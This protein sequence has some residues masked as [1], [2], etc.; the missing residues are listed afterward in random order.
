[1]NNKGQ[2]GIGALLLVFVAVIVGV[3]LFQSSAQSIGSAVNT[4]TLANTTI[5][6]PANGT[7]YVFSG[8][9]SLSSVVVYNGSAL[10]PSTNYT[11]ANDQIVNGL[12][13]ATITPTASAEYR[14]YDWNV[15]AIA[16]PDTYIA[17]GGARSIT[18]LVLVFSALAIAV[19][20]LVPS[21][22]SGVLD[23]FS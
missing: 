18:S 5:D 3:A 15:S 11:V 6:T 8:Y 12:L 10:V 14:E 21:L 20:A 23:I 22:R 1:M 2:T 13:V 9:R 4:V 19:V 16:Q 7:A 17:D